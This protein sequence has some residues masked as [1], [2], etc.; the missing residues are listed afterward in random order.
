MPIAFAPSNRELEVRKI[1]A[2][3][4]IKKHLQ[5]LGITVGSKITLISSTGGNVIVVVKE[6]RLCL[7]RTLAGKILVA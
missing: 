4:K 2:E 5:E 1:G 3:D 7:D 6:G